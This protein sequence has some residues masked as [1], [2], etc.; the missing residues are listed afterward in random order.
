MWVSRN[1]WDRLIKRVERLENDL[2][3]VYRETGMSY[4]YGVAPYTLHAYRPCD[5]GYYK[6][7]PINK[8]VAGIAEHLG[9][10]YCRHPETEEFTTKKKC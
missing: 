8:V 4:Y 2:G 1:K 6:S 10:T 3:T 9:I 5:Y 7:L